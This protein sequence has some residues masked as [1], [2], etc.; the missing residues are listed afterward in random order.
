MAAVADTEIMT[1]SE[2]AAILARGEV[3]GSTR[4]GN[5]ERWTAPG[6]TP[7]PQG[8]VDAAEIGW[9]W[10]AEKA[11]RTIINTKAKW[12]LLGLAFES[13]EVRRVTLKTDARNLRSR[14]GIERLG[15]HLDGVLRAH[16]PA[17]DGGERD[18]AVYSILA[19]EWPGMRARLAGFLAR[20]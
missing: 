3:V 8:F 1:V 5:L 9:T 7:R 20:G 15:A 19:S 14:A 11:Q 4:L 10:L 6:F 16:M 18:S 17:A 2:V 13:W 12:L